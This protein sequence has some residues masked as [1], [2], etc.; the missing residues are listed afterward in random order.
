MGTVNAD[1]HFGED[2]YLDSRKETVELF[3]AHC[4]TANE[5]G[6]VRR[7]TEYD[8]WVVAGH[9]IVG[10]IEWEQRF[11]SDEMDLVPEPTE[12]VV[13]APLADE[14]CVGLALAL[15]GVYGARLAECFPA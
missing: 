9:P 2:L 7:L 12:A 13:S 14:L 8:W 15:A 6:V 3:K 5:T 1:G 4:V 11:A 10:L